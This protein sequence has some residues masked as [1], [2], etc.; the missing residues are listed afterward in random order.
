MGLSWLPSDAPDF[1]LVAGAHLTAC[2]TLGLI[3]AWAGGRAVLGPLIGGTSLIANAALIVR[4]AM[5][6]SGGT[7][8]GSLA[9]AGPLLLGVPAA[10]NILSA[11]LYLRRSKKPVNMNQHEVSN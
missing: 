6:I 10:T 7:M 11:L 9:F 3:C 2:G 1:F 8:S 5:L 4:L